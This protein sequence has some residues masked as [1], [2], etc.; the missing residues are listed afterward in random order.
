MSLVNAGSQINIP[1]N[2]ELR[3]LFPGCVIKTFYGYADIPTEA[4]NSIPIYEAR[5]HKDDP[6]QLLT[7]TNINAILSYRIMSTV[8]IDVVNLL[9]LTNGNAAPISGPAALQLGSG[10][11][12][13]RIDSLSLRQTYP[14]NLVEAIP[15][16]PPPFG[17]GAA[18]GFR[19]VSA[20]GSGV[21]NNGFAIS[22]TQTPEERDRVKRKAAKILL[23]VT[24][25]LNSVPTS[26]DGAIE[27]FLQEVLKGS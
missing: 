16:E 14:Q 6:P 20:N 24:A 12:T 22:S 11:V 23:R 7:I 4:T 15:V 9:F 13:N 26:G 21:L 2:G 19:L 17:V 1:D 5:R 10:G 3:E 25:R 8:A 18:N 27:R